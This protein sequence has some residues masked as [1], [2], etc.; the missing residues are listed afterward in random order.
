MK[1]IFM[2]AIGIALAATTLSIQC[3]SPFPAELFKPSLKLF[4]AHAAE[5]TFGDFKYTVSDGVVVITG[6]TGVNMKV[7]IPE[8]IDEKDVAYI[9]EYA[10]SNLAID[11]VCIPSTLEYANHAFEGCNNL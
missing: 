1:K 11:E 7:M 6:Y 3:L 5:K 4:V 9:E 2:R 10:F 8:K